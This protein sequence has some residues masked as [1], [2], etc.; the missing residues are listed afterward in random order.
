VAQVTNA[1]NISGMYSYMDARYDEWIVANG[2]NLV[3]VAAAAEF[4]NTPKHSA[5]LSATYDWPL[6]MMGRAGTLSLLNSVSYKGKVY[7]SEFVRPAGVVVV[8]SAVAGN[9]MLA[10]NAYSVWDAGLVWTSADRK[11][12]VG[13][14]GRNL[15]D[16]RYKVAGYNF[17]GFFNT[18]TTF[19]GDPRTVR[20]TVGLK[21]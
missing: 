8:D 6:A 4:Q 16:K 20:L 5:N 3:N 21:Y 18:V 14:H 7:Q 9:L 13:L 17:A 2:P 10:Q 12:Q 1:F 15:T 19:Y 11:I